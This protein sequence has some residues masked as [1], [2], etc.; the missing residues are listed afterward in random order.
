MRRGRVRVWVRVLV[1]VFGDASG[2]VTRVGVYLF[3]K[4]VSEIQLRWMLEMPL[5][6]YHARVGGAR[7]EG[8]YLFK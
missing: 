3:R 7:L 8:N 1:L 6:S 5:G 2:E 4:D